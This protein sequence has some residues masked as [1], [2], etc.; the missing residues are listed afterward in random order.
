MT[1]GRVRLGGERW[2]EDGLGALFVYP[3]RDDPDSLVVALASSSPRADRLAATLALFVS[4][5]GYPDY[6]VFGSDVLAQGDGGVRAAGFF[7]R[8]WGLG[9]R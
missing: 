5:A 4:G 1:R 7:D 6:V 8:A 3:R 2:S 9:G